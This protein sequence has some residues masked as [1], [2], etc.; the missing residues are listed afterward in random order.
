M[1]QSLIKVINE[2]Y[3][4]KKCNNNFFS[5]FC[6]LISW[7]L[8]MNLAIKVLYRRQLVQASVKSR[9]VD[10]GI[11]RGSDPVFSWMTGIRI[12]YISWKI[13]IRLGLMSIRIRHPALS[14]NQF[15]FGYE[16]NFKGRIHLRLRF[17]TTGFG[18][19]FCKGQLHPDPKHWLKF[20]QKLI[21]SL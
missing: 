20:I 8:I 14:E 16:L 15:G 4:C 17:L 1:V 6:N 7:W 5:F 10:F 19:A 11:F 18:W 12:R 2:N 3:V 9:V 21:S 13:G